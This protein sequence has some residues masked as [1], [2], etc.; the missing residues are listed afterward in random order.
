MGGNANFAAAMATV[1][2]FITILLFLG[3]KYIVN[4][5]SFVMSS[6]RPM[7]AKELKGVKGVLMHIFIYLV[8][9]LSIIPQITVVYTSFLKTKVRCLFQSFR[10]KAMRKS[11]LEWEML[12]L[13]LIYME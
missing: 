3:Q 9:F 10:W 7:Q 4:K 11:F 5:K 13:I 12:Y 2:V 1:L 6:L 8:V